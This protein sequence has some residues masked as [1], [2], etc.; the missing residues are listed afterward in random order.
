MSIIRGGSS[1]FTGGRALLE[2]CGLMGS[3]LD[4]FNELSSLGSSCLEFLFD[5]ALLLLQD[6]LLLG[7][8]LLPN[9]LNLLQMLLHLT[10]L[11]FHSL[12]SLFFMFIDLSIDFSPEVFVLALSLFS[13]LDDLADSLSGSGQ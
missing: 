3:L 8:F 1:H 11:F 7:L 12:S 4:L 9:V 2:L 6:I 5:L 13:S 10:P